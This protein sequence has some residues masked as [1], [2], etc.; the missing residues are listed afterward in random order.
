MSKHKAP[1]AA[2]EI[3]SECPSP[4]L[5]AQKKDHFGKKAWEWQCP[6]AVEALVAGKGI[7]ITCSALNRQCCIDDS[8]EY[9][10]SSPK[11][12]PLRS[13]FETTMK[14]FGVRNDAGKETKSKK[15]NKSKKHK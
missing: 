13:F 8:K 1:P 15:H 6:H 5:I 12:E 7:L 4:D 2:R 3:N 11:I 14:Y 9:F 10:V